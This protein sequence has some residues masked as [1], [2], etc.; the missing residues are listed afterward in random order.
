M[1]GS[2]RCAL[3][4]LAAVPALFTCACGSSSSSSGE[5]IKCGPGTE[6]DGGEC[7]VASSTLDSSAPPVDGGADTGAPD[8]SSP[9]PDAGGGDASVA[10]AGSTAPTFGGVTSVAP[11]STTS[12]Q[13]TWAAATDAV[14]PTADI[15]YDVY[16]GTAAGG[17]NF[18][19]PTVTSPPGALS[20]DVEGLVSGSTYFVVVRARN[21]AHAEDKN[22]VEKSGTPQADTMAPA[23]AGATSAV[24]APQGSV[25]V[26]WAAAIDND[27]P[28]LGIGY[29]VYMATTSGAENFNLPS[30]AS[31]P[32]VTSYTVAA[33]PTPG[34]DYY[35]VVRAHDAAGNI[36]S[37]TVEVSSKPGADTVP[38]VFAG[39]TSA[40]TL[41]STEVTVTWDQA[42]DNTT[43][44][45]QIAY[46]IFAA[47]TPGQENYTTPSATVTGVSV[48]VVSMLH[49]ATTYYFVC[50]AH[51][52][53]GNEDGN[54]SERSAT[55]P[56]DTTPPTFAGL[57]A[58]TSVTATSVQLDWVPATDPQT[59]TPQI[60]YDVFQSTTSGGEAFTSAPTATSMPGATSITLSN[61]PPSSTLY[62]VVRARD[63]AGNEDTNTVELS[64]TTGVSFSENVQPIFTQHCAVVGCHVPG[65]PPEGQ[66]LAA[67]FAYSN[68]V[69]VPS[70]EVPADFRVDPGDPSDSYLYLKITAQ[71]SVGTYMPPPTTGDV[72][73]AADKAT[74]MNWIAQGALNN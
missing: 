31:D 1:Q 11:A 38:P 68:I 52:L 47:T 65:S 26:S 5:Q 7:Y 18:A 54:T 14:T 42:T 8:S 12:L 19:A 36:D 34:V 24:P 48:G 50:R 40:V 35:F 46:D 67:G 17:E 37:N 71:Q 3:T 45:P 21:Q 66:V 16:V 29:Y 73:S 27:T 53:S 25:V 63:L 43:P 64:T 44:Q 22:H 9:H 6:L 61:L 72:L 51:D 49:P 4:L 59:P 30:Y 74:I 62:W 13:V 58:I 28:T 15:V 60:V 20:V 55:T 41:N 32:G 33:L 70:M 57:T 2:L 69:N 56:V 23:F 39:C 10:D